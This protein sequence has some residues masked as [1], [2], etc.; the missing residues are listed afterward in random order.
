MGTTGAGTT[1]AG[2]TDAGAVGGA[3]ED[4]LAEARTAEPR[5]LEHD[6]Q[7]AWR[8]FIFAAMSILEEL[9]N[10]LETDPAIDLTL[11]EYEILVHLSEQDEQRI[12]MSDLAD[13]V[14]HSRSRLTHTVARLER[15][16][17]VER[18]RCAADGR[19]RE[20]VLTAEGMALLVRAA[21]V[22]VESVRTVLLDRVGHADFL[23]LG[24]ILRQA[25]PQEEPGS[26]ARPRAHRSPC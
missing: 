7:F 3:G 1:D 19:G 2:T 21:P 8:S 10:V 6:E 4:E 11:H 26:R 5:W 9:S 17:L 23:E 16:G 18:V 15:R 14:V 25:V 12:R 13:L 24:R 22:H 20:A